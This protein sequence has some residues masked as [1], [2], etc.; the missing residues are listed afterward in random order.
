[1]TDKLPVE[2]T[3][4]PAGS[5][6]SGCGS[7][8]VI[9][10][11]CLYTAIWTLVFLVIATLVWEFEFEGLY[12]IP[13]LRV[14]VQVVYALG[15]LLFLGPLALLW[16]SQ[17]SRRIF[18]SLSL[19]SAYTL[20][21]SLSRFTHVDNAQLAAVLQIGLTLILLALLLIISHNRRVDLGV[22][23]KPVSRAHW[24]IPL[25]FAG[26]Y[27]IVWVA[28]G[29]LGSWLD[30][31][32]NLVVGLCFGVTV[33]VLLRLGIFTN[34]GLVQ[35]DQRSPAIQGLACSAILA[36][37]LA[38]LAPI[39]MQ[40]LLMLVVPVIGWFL[41]ILTTS[42]SAVSGRKNGF[43]L[44]LILGLAVAIPFMLV[45]ADE[46]ALVTSAMKGDLLPWIAIAAVA[47]LIVVLLAWMV[48]SINKKRITS[49]K[50][51]A[52]VAGF[53]LFLWGVAFALVWLHTGPVFNGERLFVILKDQA[54]V[55]QAAKI[56]DY[57]VRRTYV[58]ETLT[59]HALESQYD[60][61]QRLDKYH[62]VYQAYYLVNGLEVK[63]GPLVRLWLESR[64]EVDR[65]LDNPIL[66]PLPMAITPA[67]GDFD[68]LPMES[69][70]NLTM[71]HAQETWKKF[72]V[73]GS[74]IVIGQSDS[75]ADGNH[76]EFADRYRGN[77]E[78]DD[79]NW[80]DPWNGSR[81]PT[82][83]GGHGTH[84]LATALGSHVGVA[85][86]ASWIGCVN[87]ARNLGNPARYLDCM[88][89]MLAPFPQDGDPFTQGEP[90]R[91][92]HVL[93]NSWGC[94][95]VEGC[96]PGVF[97]PAVDAL[98]A[99]GIFVVVGAGNNGDAGCGSVTDPPS[100]YPSVFTVGAVDEN[101]LLASFSSKGPVTLSGQILIKPNL[102][103][104]GV[105]VVSAFPGGTYQMSNGT[106]MATPH[107][108]GA[109]A[110]LWS[111]NPE[112][113]G[114]IDLTRQILQETA[115]KIDVSSELMGC[116]ANDV[117][118]NNL[119][120]YGLLNVYAAVE[121]ALTGK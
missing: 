48:L 72:N 93:T 100:L 86:G 99:A 59:R 117:V 62:I 37:M 11:L 109:V 36:V 81:S 8:A 26:A 91:S 27:G 110:L 58:Y 2:P 105:D 108:A 49:W 24:L 96:D 106:S 18:R 76:P 31:L 85:P 34:S 112:L 82:D 41:P 83:I 114:N 61:R 115:V 71:I 63:A 88:Q 30:S 9:T 119:E 32:L 73:T 23:L 17:P 113:I 38:G 104:P 44:A 89:F 65:V 98:E 80:L 118:P 60:L 46:L 66:R 67:K 103:A 56:K 87:L 68:A 95:E 120:G 50:F 7:I 28:I 97:Q 78:G 102:V 35:A 75:G 111:A 29:A 14:A 16:K 77:E 10:G 39:G 33:S 42:A 5:T 6:K 13:W 121:R 74:G 94:P 69:D 79:Y 53:S 107:V 4:Q 52:P 101:S 84:T 3:N 70:W 20:I 47:S 55:S 64:P 1:M 15:L 54:D 57:D 40:Y 90:T 116:G 12:N 22:W 51:S 25:L 19:A 92:A 43:P 45:D 21:L